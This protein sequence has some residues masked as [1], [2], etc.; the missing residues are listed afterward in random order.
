MISIDKRYPNF[1]MK[2]Q[3]EVFWI[4]YSSVNK[5]RHTVTINIVYENCTIHLFLNTSRPLVVVA[6]A[7]QGER[8]RERFRFFATILTNTFDQPLKFFIATTIQLFIDKVF[9]RYIRDL[10]FLDKLNLYPIL[11]N[12]FLIVNKEFFCFLLLS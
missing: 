8:F 2:K 4:I 7:I 5:G 12:F 9:T 3:S 11:E 10:E 6:V 1:R